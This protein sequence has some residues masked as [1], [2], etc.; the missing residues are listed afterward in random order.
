MFKCPKC[1]ADLPE[2]QRLQGSCPF[3]E[4]KWTEIDSE[5]KSVSDISSTLNIGDMEA[6][7]QELD[8]REQESPE[9]EGAHADGAPG[10]KAHTKSEP[11]RPPG[12]GTMVP[13][14]DDFEDSS[15]TVQLPSGSVAPREEDG[16]GTVQLGKDFQPDGP[17][18]INETKSP[19][20]PK[21]SDPPESIGKTIDLP[22]P[23]AGG[24]A[25]STM[26]LPPGGINQT[27]DLPEQGG[28][29]RTVDLPPGGAGGG[30]VD[31][32]PAEAGG[33]TVNLPPDGIRHTVD[34]DG[35]DGNS[36]NLLTFGSKPL[37]TSDVK[38]FWAGA[39]A[40]SPLTS[41][42]TA[43][44]SKAKELGVEIRQRII[45]S[46]EDGSDYALID[47]LGKGGM[48]IVYAANQKSL[49]R[50]VAVKTLRRGVGDRHDDRAK[51]L[52]EAV[53]TGL[54]DHP[55]IVPIHELGQTEDGTLFYSMKCVTGVEWH[56]VLRKKNESENLEIL[57]RIADAVAF[58]HSR[59]VIHR[60]L[61]PENV[62]LGEYGEVLLMDWG[63]AVDLNRDEEFTMGGT[64]AYMSPE[65]A[66][67]PLDRIGKASDIYLLGAILYEIVTGFPPHAADSVTEC[68]VA[69][70]DNVI[71]RSPVN[72]RL[73]QIAL[74]AMAS[75]PKLRY[76]SVA[77]FQEEIRKY[78]ETA[79]SLGLSTAAQ[80]ELEQA[81]ENKNYEQFSRALFGFQDAL[82]LW[83]GND[84]ARKGIGETKLA[85]ATCALEK[86]DFDLGLQ[87]LDPGNPEERVLYDR[88]KVA[89]KQAEQS[90]NNA[91]R[92]RYVAVGLLVLM[93][94]GATGGMFL[95]NAEKDRAIAAEADATKARELEEEQRKRAQKLATEEAAQRKLAEKA[96]EE[97]KLAT[98]EAKLAAEKEKEA[99][100]KEIE[101]RLVA[102]KKTREAEEERIKAEMA[103]ADEAI[104][105]QEADRQRMIAEFAKIF[106]TVGLSQ[107]KI[108]SNDIDRAIALLREVPE[109]YRGWEWRHLHYLCHP[110]TPMIATGGPATSVDISADGTKIALGTAAGVVAV[111]ALEEGKPGAQLARL[112]L[113]GPEISAL[114]FQL[115]G[116]KL[117]I[118]CEQED[119][120][121]RIWDMQGEDPTVVA[122]DSQ[123]T[124]AAD[125]YPMVREIEF[126]PTGDFALVA[127]SGA[128][129]RVN[130]ETQAKVNGVSDHV[131]R[132]FDVSVSPGGTHYAYTQENNGE[133]MV[134]ERPT[135]GETNDKR[136]LR[137]EDRAVQCQYIGAG[138]VVFAMAD[139]SIHH[140][141]PAAQSTST[142]VGQVDGQ[143][144]QIRFNPDR[145]ILAASLSDG[146]IQL[147]RLTPK[148]EFQ[149]Y[150]L[151]RGH[152]ESVADAVLSPV[153]DILV[154]ASQDGTVRVWD[155]HAYHDQKTLEHEDAVQWADFSA[156][157]LEVVTG[158]LEG[159]AYVWST[160]GGDS[161]PQQ[162]FSEGSWLQQ[163]LIRTA[164]ARFS[165]SQKYVALADPDLGINVWD[166]EQGKAVWNFPTSGNSKVLA[167]FDQNEHMVFVDAEPSPNGGEPQTVL[168]FAN[169]TGE[170]GFDLKYRI[171]ADKI[172][173][174]AVSPAGDRFAVVYPVGVEVIDMEDARKAARNSTR[175]QPIWSS[176][177][178]GIKQ[179]DFRDS[180]TLLLGIDPG[181]ATTG[182]VAVVDLKSERTIHSY[183]SAHEGLPFL[184]FQVSP[185]RSKM[186]IVYHEYPSINL[187]TPSSLRIFDLHSQELLADVQRP[188]RVH[189]PSFDPAGQI[190]YFVESEKSESYIQRWTI[191]QEEVQKVGLAVLGDAKAVSGRREIA[192]VACSPENAELLQVAYSNRDVEIWDVQDDRVTYRF[193]ASKP[194]IVTDFWND[195]KNVVTVHNDGL[196]RIWDRDSGEKIRQMQVP[197]QTLY[198]A[199]RHD[200]ALA[201]G[202]TLGDVVVFDLKDGSEQLRIEPLG[203]PVRAIAWMRDAERNVLMV[204]TEDGLLRRFD[205]E[206]G[207]LI[208][209]PFGKH[210]GHYT[211]MTSTPSGSRFAAASTD[212]S[213][214]IWLD[215]PVA[216][217]HEVTPELAQGHSSSVTAAAFSDDG[218]R[219]ITGS[220]D[221]GLIVWFVGKP[222]IE[223]DNQD[224]ADA[225][226]LEQENQ[227]APEPGEQVVMIKEFVPLKGH[228]GGITS[229]SFSADHS[230]VVTT[231]RDRRAILWYSTST[232]IGEA[233]QEQ[234]AEPALAIQ[235]P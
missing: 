179:I 208:G 55:N 40:G 189:S 52:G 95:I 182:R 143:V 218:N 158:D 80:H 94:F 122:L 226:N 14:F 19:E 109:D 41:L 72:S 7:T 44:V 146:S 103:R 84:A 12:S 116:D 114:R 59:N 104:Q 75:S 132:M 174:I 48:G 117:W 188:A 89:K 78:Q 230:S 145:R 34:L 98:E 162:I 161:E 106:S 172:V 88:L 90:A 210:N 142:L 43:T 45:S 64:P 51:F 119:A 54:L 153:E 131:L 196:V 164:R 219:L 120:Y 232:P 181:K 39:A 71:V 85:Y 157:G 11:P 102:E 201:V 163:N 24:D 60:D 211:R 118:G 29:N 50:K 194:V 177:Q 224:E 206:S 70:A 87:Q 127:F 5:G 235:R 42:R 222:E 100:D 130:V 216:Q 86:S 154:S 155:Y 81:I 3:C 18:D 147:W 112:D 53:I 31:L 129:I 57:N 140:W 61:K 178:S 171:E 228:R 36:D 32:P 58:A 35:P 115:D 6:F 229:I 207:A 190:L 65:M 110:D 151:L 121:L 187:D 107:S 10:N 202:G 67:G 152:L 217:L 180:D 192:S 77:A 108:E 25:F 23:V 124:E 223:R 17:A 205:A 215:V 49:S 225:E 4:E 125:S 199:A 79:Q 150:K 126:L 28:V 167:M 101:Q 170:R 176:N 141:Q 198:A 209:E 234:A 168:R 203:Q 149:P 220:E 1:Q 139:G 2:V 231:A 184:L 9:Q 15:S 123:D 8:A 221:S 91:R 47:E 169:A 82:A 200:D 97:A 13:S 105:R 214:R 186:A 128:L 183:P 74:K 138:Q 148:G 68:L 76:P 133:Y 134:T 111:H 63:L 137:V 191:G 197:Y 204:S 185:D 27:V 113:Q 26:E 56:R 62:M 93:L 195:D 46:S 227:A 160:V 213:V 193:N 92:A 83:D 73:K 38:K 233:P 30:T 96:T 66:K 37:G 135:W 20:G 173:T 69:A 21:S 212:K 22:A 166:I 144:S 165:S 159:R 175:P 156:D 136:S 16:D 99:A 33:Q